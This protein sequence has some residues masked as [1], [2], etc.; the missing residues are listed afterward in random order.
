MD[1]TRETP[2]HNEADKAT[3]HG[4]SVKRLVMPVFNRD[5]VIALA[6]AVLDDSVEHFDSD[7]DCHY[8]CNFCSSKFDSYRYNRE[9]FKHDLDC[10][11]LIAQ[12][13]LTGV[14]A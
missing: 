7:N 3:P 9:D 14:E 8:F 2:K 4:V 5:D 12:D 13:V 11:V 6:K 10:P 1:K